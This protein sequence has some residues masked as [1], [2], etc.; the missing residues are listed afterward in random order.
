MILTYYKNNKKFLTRKTSSGKVLNELDGLRALAIF[1]VIYFHSF[2]FFKTHLPEV[3]LTFPEWFS[4]IMKNGDNG[5]PLFF[6]ISAFILGLPFAKHHL[7]GGKKVK[8]K[9]YFIRRITRLQPTYF[10]VILCFGFLYFLKNKYELS[11]LIQSFTLSNLYL[12]NIVLQAGSFINYVAWSLEIEFQFYLILPAMAILFKLPAV[13]RRILLV[14]GILSGS[15]FHAGF[16]QLPYLSLLNYYHYFL[17][18]LLCLDLYLTKPE[19]LKQKNLISFIL[20]TT[21][22]LII[23]TQSPHQAIGVFSIPFA[24]CLILLLA[25][26]NPFWNKLFSF[27]FLSKTGTMSYSMYLIH[28]QII[29][30]GGIPIVALFKQTGSYCLLVVSVLILF[31]SIWFLSAFTFLLVE[32]PFMNPNWYKLKK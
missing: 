16:N 5:V 28:F 19:L 6:A 25:L 29:A 31:T 24:A 2:G 1:M 22:L 8:L 30:V 27:N 17:A 15:F 7:Y 4:N 3:L 32:K 23:T 9:K 21:S 12:H 14:I 20:G 13:Y 18:G 26:Q 10:I 11:T